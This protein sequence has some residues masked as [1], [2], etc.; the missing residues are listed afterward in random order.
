MK[1]HIG[2]KVKRGEER[3]V[4]EGEGKSGSGHGVC[5]SVLAVVAITAVGVASVWLLSAVYAAV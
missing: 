4:K 3:L 5:S 1:E 2:R